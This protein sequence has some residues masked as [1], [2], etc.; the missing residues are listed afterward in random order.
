M[1]DVIKLI[2][3][4]YLSSPRDI[5]ALALTNKH[6]CHV[7]KEQ[8]DDLDYACHDDNH[9]MLF[10]MMLKARLLAY[11]KLP[12]HET[13]C[14]W[15]VRIEEINTCPRQQDHHLKVVYV[16]NPR[17]LNLGWMY[18]DGVCYGCTEY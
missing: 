11:K 15:E 13:Q 2:C 9:Q 5:I 17:D 1:D 14:G 10:D 7:L 16:Y 6:W 3:T 12:Q 8:L 18:V 4:K